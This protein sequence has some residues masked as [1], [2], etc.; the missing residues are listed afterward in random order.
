MFVNIL[1]FMFHMK[2]LIN[3]FR[4]FG[5]LFVFYMVQESVFDA[6]SSNQSEIVRRVGASS[7]KAK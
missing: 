2:L 4:K 6:N 7:P 1:C 5:G 3:N